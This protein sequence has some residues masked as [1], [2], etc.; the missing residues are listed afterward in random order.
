MIRITFWTA[1]FLVLLR[2]C[3]GWHFFFEG[4]SKVK[5]AYLG[6]AASNEKP[7]SSETYFRE[8]ESWLGRKLKPM[9]LGDP[10]AEL[11]AKLTPKEDAS[12]QPADRFPDALAPEW[13]GYFAAFKS[14]YRLSDEQAAESEARF[15]KQ[16]DVYVKW[17]L[18]NGGEDPD[19]KQVKQI[20][21]KV[22]R[23]APG[24]NPG[25][26]FEEQV[27]LATRGRELLQK[28]AEVKAAYA[29]F[30]ELGRDVDGANLRSLKGDVTAIR[31]ELQKELDDQTKKMKD[32]L[33]V[34]LDARVS[35]FPPV[36]KDSDVAGQSAALAAMLTPM[37][38]G[39]NPLAARWDEY[40]AYVKD[41]SPDLSDDQ[42]ADVDARVTAAKVRFDRWLAGKDMFT[43][44]V[45]VRNDV[46]E[47]KSAYANA[48][49]R[50]APEP[51][52]DAAASPAD[53][54]RKLLA[55][56]MQA[57]L[58]GFTDALKTEIGK[59]LGEDR[60]KGYAPLVPEYYYGVVP[61]WKPIEYMDWTTRWFLAV[62]GSM[63][64]VGLFTRTSCFLAA[65]FLLMTNLI[66]PSVPWLPT[67]PNNEG[68]YLFVNKNMI[69]MVALLALMTTR[70]GLWAGLDA[71]IAYVF[72]RRTPATA[73]VTNQHRARL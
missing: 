67:A 15:K 57:D 48:E 44:E 36:P 10:D 41:F 69:E 23:K 16:Q 56:R 53:T 12:A 21:L 72:G 60:A 4:V 35:A 38:D 68:N 64:M 28:S 9:L 43:G 46:A 42:K 24:N 30:L 8:S 32:D 70:T 25:G 61:K 29:K 17:T 55:A 37:A 33:A 11:V 47:W 31:S 58:K 13:D 62:V 20:F 19:T 27:T 1:V 26:D 54:E 51:K 18:G 59:S 50:A 5:S 22:K 6:K 65:G 2:V 39:K 3:I 73:P 7:F 45:L 14:H 49:S 71:I 66:Q 34:P 52:K 40:G 63:L